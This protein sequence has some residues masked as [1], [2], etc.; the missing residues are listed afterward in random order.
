MTDEKLKEIVSNLRIT[1]NDNAFAGSMPVGKCTLVSI[2]DEPQVLNGNNWYPVTFKASDGQNYDLSL[3]GLLQAP[4]LQYSTR[5]LAQ[6]IKLLDTQKG[7]QFDYQGKKDKEVIWSK[8]W[9]DY[10]GV[11]HIKGE[12]GVISQHTFANKKVG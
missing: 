2:A 8:N 12:A 5:N 7:K 10:N 4:G 1:E 11:E 9:T 3:K 6:R